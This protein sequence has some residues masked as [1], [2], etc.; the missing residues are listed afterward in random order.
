MALA[1]LLK[2]Y[3]RLGYFPKLAEVPAV[4]VAHVRGRLELADVVEAVHESDRT[5]WCHRDFVRTRLGV[6]YTPAKVREVAEA[7][8]RKAVQSK[9]LDPPDVVPPGWT[10]SPAPCSR[11]PRRLTGGV[12]EE[13]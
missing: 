5:L 10:L 8:I 3:Q 9:D 13:R 1:V 4:V 2:C 7:A 11:W 12:A 6:K